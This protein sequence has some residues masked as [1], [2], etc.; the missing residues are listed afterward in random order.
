MVL[1]LANIVAVAAVGFLVLRRGCD[2]R[3]A[4]GSSLK[5]CLPHPDIELSHV[6]NDSIVYH[7]SHRHTTIPAPENKTPPT[8]GVF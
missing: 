2:Q 5:K 4:G 1:F 6:K 7:D 3:A 8:P